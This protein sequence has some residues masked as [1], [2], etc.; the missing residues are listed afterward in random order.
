MDDKTVFQSPPQGSLRPGQRLNGIFEIE[1]L[2][3]AGGMGEVYKGVAVDSG[4][5]VAIKLVKPEMAEQPEVMALF[6]RE[7]VILRDLAH[8][9][10]V[11]YYGFFVEPQLRR[12]Y[13]VMEFVNGVSLQKRLASGPMTPDEVRVLLRRIGG[14]LDL[15]HSY[16]IVHRDV[17]S[18]NIILP[19][20]DPR[21]AK[22]V[23]FGIARDL[24]HT[25][26]TIIGSGFAGKYKYV[27]PEQLGLAGGEVTPKSDIYSFGLVIAEALRGKP[28]DM[29][30]TQADVIEKRKRVP[31]LADVDI[32]LRPLITAMLQPN[33]AERPA[34]MAEIAAWGQTGEKTQLSTGS[35]PKASGAS[36]GKGALVGVVAAGVGVLAVVGA[37]YWFQD[38][39]GKIVAPYLTPAETPTPGKIKVP[40]LPP[41]PVETPT[42]VVTAQTPPATE[43]PT[44]EPSLTATPAP[45]QTARPPSAAD[46]KK[47]L[48]PA[49]SQP[50]VAV[51]PYPVGAALH[52]DLPGFGDPGGDGLALHATPPPPSGVTL[53]DLG[54]GHAALEGAGTSA[55]TFSFDVVAVNRA[56]KSARMKVTMTLASTPPQPA[57]ASVD[58]EPATVG[59]PYSAALPPFRSAEKFTLRADHAPAGLAFADLGGG[60]S[61]LDGTP[62]K[63]G[64]YAFEVVAVTPGGAA[65][66][67]T[68]NI[69]VAPP[70]ATP[71]TPAPTPSLADFLTRHQG[72]PCFA[73]RG[74]DD[75]RFVAYAAEKGAVTR[76]DSAFRTA[77][78]RE[79]QI[80]ADLVTPG[81]CPAVDLLR[82][83]LLAGLAG[84]RL[85]LDTTD[86][87][88]GHPLSGAVL[89]LNGRSLLLLAIDNDGVAHRLRTQIGDGGASAAFSLGLRGD[90]N[91]IGQPQVLL[92]IATDHPL[93]GLEPFQPGPAADVLRRIGAQEKEAKASAA[94][95]VFKL[96][97]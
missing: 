31:D 78:G 62:K 36:K 85:M 9:A 33:P 15:A 2:I 44:P 51:G 64:R 61:Q 76:F 30:A 79:P 81:E 14:A 56:E 83:S 1:R 37:A 39:L 12:P 40:P 58:L 42:P 20:G 8:D 27:S 89:D 95:A 38:P 66:R 96:T 41:P 32:S 74:E 94:M 67:M 50:E 57:L 11:R 53:H 77:F 45:T 73:V 4:D 6:K 43:T 28:I 52:V 97:E 68:V 47:L 29:G 59:T 46:L 21:R 5:S 80:R 71:A 23:D 92:A 75:D 90:A 10:I 84:P 22:I 93:A 87:G 13:M 86:V 88:K 72:A 69:E 26:G 16:N 18:D 60:M 91:S 82:Q 55:G 35:R 3:A 17:S 48:P 24:Q 65:G 34:S 7:A 49:P 70:G 63:P 25:D 19:E 54:D